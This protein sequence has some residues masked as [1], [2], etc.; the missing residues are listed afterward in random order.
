M[1]SSRP[2][3][4][5]KKEIKRDPQGLDLGGGGQG[6]RRRDPRGLTSG[7]EW[8]RRGPR[9]LASERGG[10]GRGRAP[11]GLAGGGEK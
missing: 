2:H 10:Q 6:G 1:R 11:T 3:F 4:W 5:R 9:G 7:G 8:G